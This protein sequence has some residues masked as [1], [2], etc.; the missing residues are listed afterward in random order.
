VRF[1]EDFDAFILICLSIIC[2]TFKHPA[3]AFINSLPSVH[4]KGN[5][6]RG[7][8]KVSHGRPG[9][10]QRS[11]TLFQ[12]SR[13]VLGSDSTGIALTDA[14]R[15]AGKPVGDVAAVAV[16]GNTKS[17]VSTLIE[18][19]RVVHAGGLVELLHTVSLGGI[20]KLLESITGCRACDTILDHLMNLAL[21]TRVLHV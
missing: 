19:A 1:G 16:G 21:G 11:E 9:H 14:R 15:P 10:F 17:Q 13:T 18:G 2:C 6:K 8:G 4:A 7:T 12:R 3:I 5:Q 20:Q